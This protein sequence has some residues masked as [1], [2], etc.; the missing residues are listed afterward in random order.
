MT[1]LYKLQLGPVGTTF[2]RIQSVRLSTHLS[3]SLRLFGG[4]LITGVVFTVRTLTSLSNICK[5]GVVYGVILILRGLYVRVNLIGS[6][7][8]MWVNSVG[9][10][11]GS[12]VPCLC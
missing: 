7:D 4:Q 1:S 3:L 6:V 8:I 12:V 10:I 2:L 11:L 5:V 9:S